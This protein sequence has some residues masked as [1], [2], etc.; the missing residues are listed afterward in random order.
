MAE[1]LRFLADFNGK[2]LKFHETYA[3]LLLLRKNTYAG[4][5]VGA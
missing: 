3:K 2:S 1:L 5:S 4:V